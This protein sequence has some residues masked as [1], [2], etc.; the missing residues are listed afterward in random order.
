MSKQKSWL[1]AAGVAAAV[2]S[3]GKL[4]AAAASA[5]A[6]PGAGKVPAAQ[7]GQPGQ[8]GPLTGVLSWGWP[9]GWGPKA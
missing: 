8:G 5:P 3:L 2:L 6:G 9:I 1:L 7:A 4:G